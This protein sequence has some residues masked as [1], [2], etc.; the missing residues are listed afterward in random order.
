[1]EEE[2]ETLR[3]AIEYK[4][5]IAALS[6]IESYEASQSFQEA[7]KF[8]AFKMGKVTLQQT[9]QGTALVVLA[10]MAK[11]L[12]GYQMLFWILRNSELKRIKCTLPTIRLKISKPLKSL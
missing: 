10:L 2:V 11:G 5:F 6:T 9:K 12:N 8:M 4:E 1:M 7:T 3:S